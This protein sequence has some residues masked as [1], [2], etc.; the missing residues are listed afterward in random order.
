[1]WIE[2]AGKRVGCVMD[3]KQGKIWVDKPAGEFK[4]QYL[5]Q[6]DGQ[7]FS[8]NYK[9]EPVHSDDCDPYGYPYC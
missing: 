5:V 8:I 4:H 7:E 9:P 3:R 2:I 6:V 1:M